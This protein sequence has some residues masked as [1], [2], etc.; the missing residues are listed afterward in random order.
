MPDD[1]HYLSM[2]VE[3]HGRIS[4][5]A[6]G[7]QPVAVLDRLLD[8]GDRVT[9]VRGNA[10]RELVTLARGGTTASPTP[11]PHGRRRSSATT[12]STGS[13]GYRTR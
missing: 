10:D 12:T 1:E 11:S 7:P 13:P 9:W 5:H 2:P 4:R 8:L 6:H 3:L